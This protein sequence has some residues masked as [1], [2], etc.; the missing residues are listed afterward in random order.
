MVRFTSFYTVHYLGYTEFHIVS[1][2]LL[3]RR[4]VSQE[5]LVVDKV[6]ERNESWHS[7]PALF[8]FVVGLSVWYKDFNPF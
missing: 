1:P 2:I 8:Y 6:N 3:Q 5:C 7:I 4:M